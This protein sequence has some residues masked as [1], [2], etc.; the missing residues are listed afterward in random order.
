[1][2][3]DLLAGPDLRLEARLRRLAGGGHLL[4]GPRIGLGLDLRDPLRHLALELTPDSGL[5]LGA[6]L[7]QQL[8]LALR[9][10]RV[11]LDVHLGAL[12]LEPGELFAGFA[13]G[14]GRLVPLGN[15]L[16][17]AVLR[18]AGRLG[19]RGLRLGLVEAPLHLLEGPGGLLTF[20][21]EVLLE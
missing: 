20:A 11:A 19:P 12:V 14:G 8:P 9:A 18:L 1:P 10:S 13:Q 15:Q 5:E 7:L 16:P 6:A 3:E 4:A 21:L 17:L 2:D